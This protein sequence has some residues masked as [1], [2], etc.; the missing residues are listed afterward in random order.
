MYTLDT[1]ENRTYTSVQKN[2]FV[3]LIK[4]LTQEFILKK[5]LSSF[6]FKEK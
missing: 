5:D 6:Q 2:M 3:I 4:Y 1:Y